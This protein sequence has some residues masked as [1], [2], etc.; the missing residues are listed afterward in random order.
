MAWHWWRKRRLRERNLQNPRVNG[1]K[2]NHLLFLTRLAGVA[3]LTWVMYL[4]DRSDTGKTSVRGLSSALCGLPSPGRLALGCSWGRGKGMTF[5]NYCLY[6]V[7][8]CPIIHSQSHGQAQSHRVGGAVRLQDT[9]LV[10]GKSLIRAIMQS[11]SH[12]TKQGKIVPMPR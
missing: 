10:T 4:A 2:T 3:D 12:N 5:S 9:R 11:I 7:D 1:L 6:Q 8:L